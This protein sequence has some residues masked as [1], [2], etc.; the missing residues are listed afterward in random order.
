M[1]AVLSYLDYAQLT[2]GSKMAPSSWLMPEFC[3][4]CM[5]Q[6]YIQV[7]SL[8]GTVLNAQGRAVHIHF[9]QHNRFFL[10]STAKTPTINYE[11]SQLLYSP[12]IIVA[13][14]LGINGVARLVFCKLSDEC[15]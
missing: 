7:G 1:A 10:L 13:L 8:Y 15:K 3:K 14:Y 4:V 12:V 11:F 6:R 9:K 5:D 2:T